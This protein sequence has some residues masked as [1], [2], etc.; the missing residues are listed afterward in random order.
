MAK[1]PDPNFTLG[2]YIDSGL[3]GAVWKGEQITPPRAVA[4]KIVNLE[5]GMTF[6]AADHARGLVRAGPHPNLVTVYQV[7]KVRHPETNR[8][9]DAVVMEWLDG[10][11]LGQRL[12]GERL[13][14]EESRQLCVGVVGAI[15][16]LHDNEVTHSDLHPGNVIVT[17]HG[18]RVID[19]DYSSAKSLA[20]LTTMVRALR[21]QADVDQVIQIVD[22]VI[23]KTNIDQAY[24]NANQRTLRESKT[25]DEVD[26]FLTTVLDGAVPVPE[27]PAAG[28]PAGS[29]ELIDKVE[30]ALET[31]RGPTLRRLVMTTA[32]AISDDFANNATYPVPSPAS[33]EILRERIA[34]YNSAM[35][36]LLPALGA[37]GY[38]G[39]KTPNLITV[40]AIDRIANAHERNPVQSG[41]S[42]LLGVRRY[43]ALPA[44][45][46]AGIG[47]IAG[48]RYST[49]FQV[50]RDTTYYEHGQV[51]RQLWTETA[52]WAAENR[53]AWNQILG[54]DLI[55]PV[56]QFL[57]D[58]LRVP[59]ARLVPSAVRYLET[60]DRFE[61]F[62]SL[63]FYIFNKRA[64]G[65]NF[66]WRR[67]GQRDGRDL[68]SD[69][70]DEAA[71]AGASW[72]P[73][74]AGLLAPSGKIR[75]LD[76]LDEFRESVT[77]VQG[78][79]HIR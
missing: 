12:G 18:P 46:A 75:V 10:P 4:I 9:V 8:V 54:R 37:L 58:S 44:L 30:A 78:S 55:F 16:H 49:L 29:G 21:I 64:L 17:D 26:A 35:A 15:R 33:N 7:T 47:A 32:S 52:Y 57:E 28:V 13:S 74:K 22:W 5:T 73:L 2:E 25:L 79:Y 20:R 65:V 67:R 23:R 39:G 68:L 60:F 24:F 66:M 61:L 42:A 36:P 62:A 63:D 40:E 43:P 59:L 41:N 70:R 6:N 38:W 45:Y 76:L 69:I 14:V 71:K 31:R 50:L 27:A 11:S 19:I 51:K 3:Y 48:K 77:E 72:G 1:K 53:E 34:A 56:S